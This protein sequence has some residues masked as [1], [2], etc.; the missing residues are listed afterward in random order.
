M[1][2]FST[3]IAKMQ[4]EYLDRTQNIQGENEV[5]LVNHL[6]AVRV[7]LSGELLE[8]SKGLRN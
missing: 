1:L 2:D 5:K 6:E 3:N 8:Y 7:K 4:K